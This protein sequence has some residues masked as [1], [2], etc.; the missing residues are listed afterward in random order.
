VL[1]PTTRAPARAGAR[2]ARPD[3]AEPFDRNRGP[4]EL[5]AEMDEH[6]LGG[7]LDAVAGGQIVHAEPFVALGP[8][9]QL[10]EI[11]DEVRRARAH[12][13]AGEENVAERS[14]RPPVRGEDCTAIAS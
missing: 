4:F 8:E 1:T 6:S 10:V 13:R 12:V 7:G 2:S 14:E 5:P 11:G 3:L 9:R